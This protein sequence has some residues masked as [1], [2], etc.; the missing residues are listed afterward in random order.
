M[1]WIGKGE[2]ELDG[3]AQRSE[4]ESGIYRIYRVCYDT[5]SCMGK[6]ETIR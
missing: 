3:K 4:L 6:F 1:D 5:T 2:A